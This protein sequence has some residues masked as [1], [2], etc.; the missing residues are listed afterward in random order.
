EGAD[1]H[2]HDHG[3][4]GHAHSH[5]H[6]PHVWL[7]IDH[8]KRMVQIICDEVKKVDA[9][10]AADYD[11]NAAAY[12]AELDKLKD[13]GRKLLADVPRDKRKFVTMHDSLGYFS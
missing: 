6:D 13:D 8:A 7:G 3:A 10:R 12:L 5:G 1:D 2:G 4:A 11:K 9:A